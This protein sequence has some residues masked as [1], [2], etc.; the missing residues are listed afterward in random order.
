MRVCLFV[1]ADLNG[2]A[3]LEETFGKIIKEVD[4]IAYMSRGHTGGSDGCIK[5]FTIEKG[6]KS[7]PFICS[8]FEQLAGMGSIFDRCIVIRR[9]DDNSLEKLA[10]MMASVFRHVE[11]VC[12]NPAVLKRLT[13]KLS[14][15]TEE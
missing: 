10:C 5:K 8:S 11:I 6:I 9:Q 1:S 13:R 3:V 14:T 15:I 4:Y 2:Q 12:Y 7:C